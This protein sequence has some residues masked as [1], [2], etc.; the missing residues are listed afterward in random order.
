MMCTNHGGFEC[1]F[2]SFTSNWG[3]CVYQWHASV[4]TI[5]GC[6]TT[7][8]IYRRSGVIQIRHFGVLHERSTGLNAYLVPWG[9]DVVWLHNLMLG[10]VRRRGG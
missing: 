3:V 10:N 1:F 8:Y 9:L 4:A 5:R 2:S 7:L 6:F